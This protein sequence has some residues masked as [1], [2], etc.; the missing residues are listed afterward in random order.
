MSSN[1]PNA[2]CMWNYIEACSP[3]SKLNADYPMLKQ[4]PCT[5]CARGECVCTSK[6]G[7]SFK[8]GGSCSICKSA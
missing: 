1:I 3:I 2:T 8:L 5:A 6:V 4:V 7:S